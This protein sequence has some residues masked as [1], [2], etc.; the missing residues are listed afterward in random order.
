[1]RTSVLASS[2]LLVRGVS[3]RRAVALAAIAA[4]FIGCENLEERTRYLTGPEAFEWESHTRFHIK[5]KKDMWGQANVSQGTLSVFLR[6]FPPGT[7]LTVGLET[8]TADDQG[9]ANA[10]TD[11]A[12]LFGT[13]PTEAVARSEAT[14]E[15]ATFTITPPNGEPIEV[16][17][18]PKTIYGVKDTLLSVV[19]GPVLFT[20][21]TDVEGPIRNA[22]WWHG[23]EQT[24]IGAPAPTVADIDAVVFV[25]RPEGTTKKCTGYTDDKGNPQPDVTLH[26]KDTVVTIHERRTGRRV[27]TRTFPPDDECPAWLTAETGRKTSRTSPEPVDEV[28]AWLTEQIDNVSTA[29]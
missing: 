12:V 4:I 14:L 23:I 10:G 9:V 1:M 29:P 8:A 22:I 5:G 20:G 13:L 3:P 25:E 2:L 18:P 27:A 7:T 16:P 26:L 11:I 15:G 17:I 28:R 6:A 24:V 19:E 21:E